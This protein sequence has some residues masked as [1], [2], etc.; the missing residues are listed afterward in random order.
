M[1]DPQRQ[2][3]RLEDAIRRVGRLLHSVDVLQEQRELIAAEARR[4]VAGANTRREALRHFDQHLV[5]GGVPE[6][7][8]DRLEVVEV[9][10]HDGDALVLAPRAGDR[11]PDALGEER[12]VGEPGD[13]VVEGLMRELFLERLALADVAAVEDDAAD[14]LVAEQV[15]AVE[16]E[17][18]RRAVAVDQRALDHLRL[19]ARERGHV[20]EHFADTVTVRGIEELFEAPPCHLLRVIAEQALDRRALIGDDPVPADHGDEVAGVPDER[21]EACLAAAAVDL[22]GQRRALE[23]E[24][25]E[26]RERPQ[27]GAN[28][29][30]DLIAVRGGEQG[31]VHVGRASRFLAEGRH[32][33]G[34]GHGVSCGERHLVDLLAAGRGHKIGSRGAQHPL[35]LERALLLAHEARHPRHDQAEQHDGGGPDDREVVVTGVQVVDDPDRRGNQGGAGEQAE[36]EASEH[37]ARLH[38]GPIELRHRRVERG[39]APEQVEADPAHVEPELVVVGPLEQHQAV[40]E[41]RDQQA[42]DAGAHQV[43]GQAPLPSVQGEPHG[44][45]EQQHVGQRI[46]HGDEPAGRRE[47]MVVDVR[48]D[49]PDPRRQR[50]PDRQDRGVDR[51]AAIGAPAAASL[52]NED[53]GDEGRVDRQIRASPSDGNGTSR[54]STIG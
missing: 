19:L 1:R 3:Q 23:R 38:R 7:V 9:E 12:P 44:D 29:L 13:R 40:D 48:R 36:T 15:R 4:R 33:V 45:G 34:A 42:D 50:E 43:E 8:V 53:P 35:A 16:L 22:L 25:H 2:R 49:Q 17:L 30:G 46:R 28:G 14:V 54:W 37:P 20:D 32:Q 41:V 18:V 21:A 27:R 31:V 47:R 26:R 11:V 24:R 6:A 10:E 52:E 5:A 39:G 51:A